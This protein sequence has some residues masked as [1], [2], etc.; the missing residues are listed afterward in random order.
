MNIKKERIHAVM[1]IPIRMLYRVRSVSLPNLSKD[2]KLADMPLDSSEHKQ[3][4]VHGEVS[5]DLSEYEFCSMKV[6]P[7][8]KNGKGQGYKSTR[9]CTCSMKNR[10]LYYLAYHKEHCL[11]MNV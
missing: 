5:K 4:P 2:D 11:E 9:L 3:N 8:W 7:F 1:V 6:I 10:L